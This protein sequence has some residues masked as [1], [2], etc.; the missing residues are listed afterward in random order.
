MANQALPNLPRLKRAPKP[1]INDCACGCG[2]KTARRF[3]P[4]H[5]S[6]LHARV[7]RI[8]RGVDIAPFVTKDELAAAMKAAQHGPNLPQPKMEAKKTKKQEREEKRQA[9]IARQLLSI[10]E[11][12]ATA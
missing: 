1:K 4:G 9:E 12:Y 7:L 8:Q 6:R 10:D 2:E 3:A 11:K 5:D